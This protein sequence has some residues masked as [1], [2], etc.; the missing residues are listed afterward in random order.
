M[1]VAVGAQTPEGAPH[2]DVV[3]QILEEKA[4]RL[5]V[6]LDPRQLVDPHPAAAAGRHRAVAGRHREAAARHRGAAGRHHGG[7]LHPTG[8][9]VKIRAAADR[10]GI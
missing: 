10:P 4:A 9:S 5:H 2:H 3:V 7:V 8:A 1:T 6:D